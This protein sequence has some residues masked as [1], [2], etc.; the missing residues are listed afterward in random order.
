MSIFQIVA[1]LFA[2]FM[3]YVVSIHGKKKTLKVW[4]VSLW[5]TTWGSFIALALF[6]YLLL[7]IAGALHF[8]RVFD[9]LLIIALMILTV[10]VFSSY[11]TQKELK[12]KLEE[13]VRRDAIMAAQQFTHKKRKSA[14]KK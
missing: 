1:V 7:G 12:R 13:L 2:L 4:E 5:L 9:L 6:P 10:V 8:S 11:F 3:M 14:K